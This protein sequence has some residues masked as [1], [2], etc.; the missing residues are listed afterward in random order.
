MSAEVAVH[1]VQWR[2]PAVGPTVK[3]LLQV[4]RTVLF[5]FFKQK[6]A[7]E[8]LARL[9]FR[10]VLFRSLGCQEKCHASE[11]VA[12]LLSAGSPAGRRLAVARCRNFRADRS[13]AGAWDRGER[14]DLHAVESEIG[15]ASC[16]E[17]V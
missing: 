17:R 6:T 7:Y 13:G 16:R 4:A 12:R 9:E 15:R 14:G 8:I 2:W 1:V 11:D 3:K 10:R 5:F